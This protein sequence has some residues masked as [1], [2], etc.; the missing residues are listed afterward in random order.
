MMAESDDG[1]EETSALLATFAS[2]VKIYFESFGPHKCY[3]YNFL[4]NSFIFYEEFRYMVK[5]GKMIHQVKRNRP[6]S[7]SSVFGIPQ[8]LL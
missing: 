7:P 1:S 3:P 4:N 5:A 8:A 6:P 2:K